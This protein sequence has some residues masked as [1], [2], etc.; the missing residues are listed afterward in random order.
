MFSAPPCRCAR[1]IRNRTFTGAVTREAR[2]AAG[3]RPGRR[4]HDGAPGRPPQSSRSGRAGAA[5][6]PAAAHSRLSW[7]APVVQRAR[8][9]EQPRRQ[10]GGAAEALPVAREQDGLAAGE[11]G[12]RDPARERE[13][14]RVVHHRHARARSPIW[15]SEAA[16][17]ARSRSSQCGSGK[18]SRKPPSRSKAS[19]AVGDV[20]GP[21][22][23]RLVVLEAVLVQRVERRRGHRSLDTHVAGVG[24]EEVA[25]RV[26]P[27]RG[28]LRVV[29]GE[30]QVLAAGRARARVARRRRPAA[31]ARDHATRRAAPPTELS[32][33]GGVLPSSTT[34]TSNRRSVLWAVRDSS[35]RARSAGRSR[36]GT[37]TVAAGGGWDPDTRKA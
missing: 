20:A 35:S 28:D 30:Q 26:H 25:R 14:A 8:D 36:V 4:H 22:G 3:S 5:S 12:A 13:R 37:T 15:P 23:T 21:V 1:G 33:T 17:K 10:A 16:R 24:V 29:V 19:R 2:L 32:D 6:G 18:R 31:A 27:G 34:T 7:T 11:P 9:R